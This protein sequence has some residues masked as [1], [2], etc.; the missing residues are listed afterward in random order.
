MMGGSH[1]TH[2]RLPHLNLMT[3][4]LWGTNSSH[5]Q[6]RKLRPSEVKLHPGVQVPKGAG[7]YGNRCQA[8]FLGGVASKLTSFLAPGALSMVLLCQEPWG[9]RGPSHHLPPSSGPLSA[10]L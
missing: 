4:L 2:V 9:Q 7:D 1:R 5:L 6:M 3:A 8:G 10:H